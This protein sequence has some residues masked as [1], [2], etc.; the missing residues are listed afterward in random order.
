[1]HTRRTSIFKRDRSKQRGAALMVMLVIMVLGALTFLVSAL[2]K[3]GMQLQ[4]D[5]K[6]AEAL[7]QAKNALIGYAA[8]DDN[9]PG[10]L[11]CPDVDDDGKLTMNVDYIG[12]NCVSPIGRLPWKTLGLPELRDGSGEHLWYAASKTFWAGGNATL[13]SD[14]P[15]NLTISG[16]TAAN[17]VIAVIFAPGSVLP[18]KSRSATQTAACTT[19]TTTL[20]E[21]QCA[22]NYLEGSNANQNLPGTPNTNYQTAAASATF[23]DQLIFITRDQLFSLIEK[24]VGNEIKNVLNTY[25]AAWGGLPLAAPFADP[26]TSSFTGQVATH[27]GL[28]A[29]DYRSYVPVWNA[30]PSISFSGNIT[31]SMSCIR[32]NG[33]A[34]NSRWRCCNVKNG[35]CTNNNITIP[36][37]VTVTI[38]GSLNSVG[39]GFWRPHNISNICEVRARNSSGTTV[40]TTSLFAPNS[41]TITNNLNSDGSANII[42]R[43]TGKSGD[44]TLQRIE[45]RDI[46]S[47]N[48][49]IKANSD[50][51]NCTPSSS[52]PVMPQWLFNS[53]TGND[54]RQVAYYA[55]SPGYAP[56]NSACN[57]LPGTPSCLTVNGSGGG[58]GKRAVVVMAGGAL[59]GQ[60]HPSATLS[61]YLEDENTTVGNFIYENKNRASDFN[62]QVISVTP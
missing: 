59:S 55:I 26:S 18:G 19:T 23:N 39:M 11:P 32:S 49:D 51:N 40:L 47:Y 5:D 60:T 6:T 16:S 37:G 24:R 2:N 62:D 21:S 50:T 38:T 43:A 22:T 41:V 10:E 1:M 14:T 42:F 3:P 20:P 27:K 9:R 8:S 15:G 46:L 30:P 29:V 44:T 12:S 54:W 31:G 4:R 35:A 17:Q 33:A 45:L 57:P 48:T 58:N 13:N 25:Y 7:A 53:S 34:T 36:S 61:N 56:G 52:S 28:L